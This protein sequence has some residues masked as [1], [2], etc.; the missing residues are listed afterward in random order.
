[1]NRPLPATEPPWWWVNN[2]APMPASRAPR[3]GDAARQKRRRKALVRDP[4]FQFDAREHIAFCF[5]CVSRS[6]PPDDHA[7]LMLK[8]VFDLS[9]DDGADTLGLS[10]SVFRHRVSAAR[11][12]MQTRFDGLCALVNKKG[13]CWQC[14]GLR[15]LSHSEGR[16]EE[17]AA[18][19][20]P[21]RAPEPHYRSRLRVVQDAELH[22]GKSQSLHDALFR[23]IDQVEKRRAG[24]APPR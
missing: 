7:A 4:S 16:G 21:G 22:A 6:L 24:D 15:E 12:Q 3:P 2:G 8:D 18:V 10:R 14:A 5:T 23:L 19:L 13:A 17:P 9:N 11:Q 1:M 20:P